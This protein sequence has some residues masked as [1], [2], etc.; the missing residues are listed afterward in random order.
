MATGRPGP[1]NLR[2]TG[3]HQAWPIM[4]SEHGPRTGPVHHI[5]FFYG[6]AHQMKQISARPCPAHQVLKLL[7]PARPMISF[8]ILTR[9]DPVHHLFCI[10][11]VRPDL[12]QRPMAIHGKL[13]E[14]KRTNTIIIAVYGDIW[15]LTT[16]RLDLK[17]LCSKTINYEMRETESQL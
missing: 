5:S 15:G 4:F 8:K 9:P 12:D 16:A 2:S 11:S 1:S 6:Q 13:I 17:V 7:G 14:E 3:R 10:G